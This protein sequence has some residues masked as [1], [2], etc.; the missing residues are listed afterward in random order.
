MLPVMYAK[1][2]SRIAQS[3]LMEEDIETRYCFMMLMAIAD[4]GGDVIGTDVALAR[5]VNLP[6]DVFRRCIVALMAPDPDSNSQVHDGRRVVLSESGRGYLIVNYC[7]YRAIKTAD[8]KKAYMREYMARRRKAERGNDVAD[9]NICKNVLNG[10][11]HAEGEAESEAEGEE[12]K[13]PSL[14]KEPTT[15][16][17]RETALVEKITKGIKEGKNS[18]RIPTTDQS[19]RIAAIFHRRETTAWSEKEVE[20]YKRIGTAQP[21]DLTLVESYYKASLPADSDYRRHD[22]C[23]F[24]NNWQG[25]VDRARKWKNGNGQPKQQSFP[26]LPGHR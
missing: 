1:L 22:L 19:K 20:S 4:S 5:T 10:V 11:T 24:L 23:T 25:E 14:P 15:R 12:E 21:D 7:T 18:E 6:L 8:E 13:D 26:K 17:E 2:F 9:V 3:S 16:D